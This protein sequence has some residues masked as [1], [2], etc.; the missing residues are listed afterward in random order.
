MSLTVNVPDKH[1]PTGAKGSQVKPITEGTK[2]TVVNDQ[3]DKTNFWGF[4]DDI[5][6][7]ASDTIGR[8]AQIK[9]D[10]FL[11]KIDNN[12]PAA[13]VD[14][15]GKPDAELVKGPQTKDAQSFTQK[16]Q[17]KLLVGGAAVVGLL[18]LYLVTRG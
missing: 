2:M 5:G 3:K 7:T 12:T 13:T 10:Q 17:K 14:T 15:R 16:Y 6:T 8:A 9:A 11:T 18:T 4:L 1:P